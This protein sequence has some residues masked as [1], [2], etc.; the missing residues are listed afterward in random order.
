MR[1]DLFRGAPPPAQGGEG[2]AARW[3]QIYYAVQ[4]GTIFS[5]QI[6]RYQ[7]RTITYLPFDANVNKGTYDT[8]LS[9]AGEEGFTWRVRV[10]WSVDANCT[11]YVRKRA[12]DGTWS[13]GAA[14]AMPTAGGLQVDEV[15]MAL[16]P[17]EGAGLW[18][19]AGAGATFATLQIFEEV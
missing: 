9:E 18:L 5:C 11:L 4:G 19:D 15:E 8:A 16:E 12:V 10:R 1:V 7:T 14:L 6:G 13:D 2:R 3:A 17:G